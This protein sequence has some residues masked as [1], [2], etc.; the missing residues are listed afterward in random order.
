ME[1]DDSKVDKKYQINPFPPAAPTE[2]SRS[3][4]PAG[5][6]N[7]GFRGLLLILFADKRELTHLVERKQ[8]D[9]YEDSMHQKTTHR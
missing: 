2:S 9:F 1:L 7:G 4:L 3:N 5:R 8:T 6:V